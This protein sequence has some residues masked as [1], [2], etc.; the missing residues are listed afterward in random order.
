LDVDYSILDLLDIKMVK[1]RG[2]SPVYVSDSAS[3]I[4]MNETAVSAM[5]MKDPIGKT[6]RVWGGEYRIIGVVKD[7]H[8][9][10]LYEKIKPCFMQLRPMGRTVFVRLAAGQEAA[11]IGAI[12]KLVR[13]YKPDLPFEYNFIDEAYQALYVSEQ[14]VAVLSRYFAGFAILISCLGLFGLA[15]FTTQKRQKE[16]SI[17]K[18]IG[19]TAGGIAVMLSRDFLK[20]VALAILIAFPLSWW[21]M[22][23]WLENFAYHISVSPVLFLLA[24][25][26]VLLI[27]LVTIGYQAVRAAIA[28]PVKSLRAE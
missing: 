5:G 27:T 2:F 6:F 18:I 17:R 12:G 1:G 15:A 4:V 25:L 26:S 21:L 28:N 9:Q 8:Y 10:S 23:R 3:S 16:I 11:T 13:N 20:L 7:F 24:G 22:N 19:A 14:R